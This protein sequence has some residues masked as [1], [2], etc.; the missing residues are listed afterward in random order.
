MSRGEKSHD[1]KAFSALG[2]PP[3]IQCDLNLN[4]LYR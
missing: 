4:I 1:E 3:T 2:T